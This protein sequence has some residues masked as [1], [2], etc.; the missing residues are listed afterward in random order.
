MPS[1]RSFLIGASAAGGALLLP[2]GLA[3]AQA[4]TLSAA[5]RLATSR[6]ILAADQTPIDIRTDQV[7]PGL[8]LPALRF[9]YPAET[10]VEVFYVNKD[11][12]AGCG[13][14]DHEETVEA[15]V[16]H[17]AAWVTLGGVR[18]D[19]LQFHFHTASEHRVNGHSFPMEQHFVHQAA[20]GTLLVVGVFLRGGGYGTV[21]DQVLDTLP[22]ECGGHIGV[23]HVNLC[24]AL[25]GD[26]HHWRYTGSLTTAPFTPGVRWHVLRE[27]MRV[28][29]TTL[30]RFRGLFPDGN[31]RPIQP[32]GD[33]VVRL[34]RGQPA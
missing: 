34:G 16:P 26:L 12:D 6:A 24:A 13:I 4:P 10:H 29:W 30:A 14:R 27:S 20:D 3:S 18:Y 2:A 7:V 19:L 1:R 23:E 25:P 31:S 32:T 9:H 22:A 8:Q 11:G 17:G 5:Q 15:E 21:V 33:R 28:Q